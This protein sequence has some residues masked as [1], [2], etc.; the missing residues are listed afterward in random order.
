MIDMNYFKRLGLHGGRLV[1]RV[2]AIVGGVVSASL[3][4]GLRE[5]FTHLGE[6]TSTVPES[7]F[8]EYRDG[9]PWPE[10]ITHS[11]WEALYGKDM[12]RI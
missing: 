7:K 11:D 8:G 4:N 1:W 12:K 5:A 10:N 3:V 2:F 6:E 9:S